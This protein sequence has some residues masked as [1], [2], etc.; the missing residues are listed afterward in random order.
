MARRILVV[1]DDALV[2]KGASS[3]LLKHGFEVLTARTIQEGFLLAARHQPDAILLDIMFPET[4]GEDGGTLAQKLKDFE[5]TAEIPVVFISSLV[6]APDVRGVRAAA[7]PYFL[8]KPL[9]AAELLALLDRI[10]GA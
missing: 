2:L 1:D 4:P 10:L 9:V 7:S 3:M 8:P 5:L 6:E